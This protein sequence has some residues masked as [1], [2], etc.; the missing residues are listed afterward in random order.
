MEYF[1]QA[2][3]SDPTYALA[4]VGIADTFTILGNLGFLPPWEVFPKAKAAARKALEIDDT[5]G[6]A[7]ASLAYINTVYDWDWLAAEREFKR[8]LELNPNYETAHYFYAYYLSAMGRF[9]EAINETKRAQE[10]D[11]LS[12]PINTA[13]GAVNSFARHYDEA[14]EQLR[15][16]LEMNPNFLWARTSLGGTYCFMEMWEEAIVELQKVLTIAGDLPFALGGLGYAYG[17]SG[18]KDEA[19]KMLNRLIELSKEKYVSPIYRAWIYLGLG[20]MDQAF[21]H[22]EKAYLERDWYLINLKIFP[23]F[24]SL[25]SDPRFTALLKKMGFE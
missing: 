12:L 22:L 21:E 1:Q 23:G 9:D 3:E 2:I 19:L 6:E 18:Q 5:L 15:K 16:T 24:D 13:V 10:L 17:F 20:E 25:R 14:I 11:P 4:Y 7:H 8:S